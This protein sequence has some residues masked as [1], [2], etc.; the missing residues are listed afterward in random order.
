M[1]LRELLNEEMPKPNEFYAFDNRENSY[2]ASFEVGDKKYEFGAFRRPDEVE[3]T[4]AFKMDVGKVKPI[5]ANLLG[6]EDPG[7]KLTKSGNVGKVFA[8]VIAIIKDFIRK[9]NP[10]RIVFRTSGDSLARE[11]LYAKWLQTV[12]GYTGHFQAHGQKFVMKRIK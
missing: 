11:R 2:R 8:T 6:R 9:K 1:K 5:I 7:F 10:K 4:M 3:W 12:K